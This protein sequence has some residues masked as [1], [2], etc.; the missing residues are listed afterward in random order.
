MCE[1]SNVGLRCIA[2][3]SL[4]FLKL[5]QD[6]DSL[7][8]GR[9]SRKFFYPIQIPERKFKSFLTAPPSGSTCVNFFKLVP[10][11]AGFFSKVC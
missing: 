5:R 1:Y 6:F 2:R 3:K 7:K 8:T 4:K 10:C 9:R 11:A